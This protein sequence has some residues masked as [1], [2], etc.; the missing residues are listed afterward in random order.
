MKRGEE[1]LVNFVE[2]KA[3]VSGGEGKKKG[4]R[5]ERKEERGRK[6]EREK[7]RKKRGKRGERRKHLGHLEI[8]KR[9]GKC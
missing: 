8:G 7:E 9:V 1:E 4:K 5:R 3:K 2:K 6:K